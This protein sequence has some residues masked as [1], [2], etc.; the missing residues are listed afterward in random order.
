MVEDPKL[1]LLAVTVMDIRVMT[2]ALRRSVTN[3]QSSI[4]QFRHA[5]DRKRLE[6][7]SSC[8]VAMLTE[9]R[10]LIESAEQAQDVVLALSEPFA[11]E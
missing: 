3:A 10:T 7:I 8:L 4:E 2:D 11:S 6:D 1:E 9:S 5:P